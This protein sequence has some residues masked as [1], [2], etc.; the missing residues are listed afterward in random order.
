MHYKLSE[1]RLLDHEKPGIGV[2]HALGL[3]YPARRASFQRR[4][5]VD[6]VQ[7]IELHASFPLSPPDRAR[8][9]RRA[10]EEIES[11]VNAQVRLPVIHFDPGVPT[12]RL[13]AKPGV[14]TSAV[15]RSSAAR[16][17][18]GRSEPAP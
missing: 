9:L 13:L 7:G 6:P 18:N 8:L 2:E 17:G 14:D 5:G 3:F 12:V 4:Y 16:P 10:I 11:N 1:Y 15:P